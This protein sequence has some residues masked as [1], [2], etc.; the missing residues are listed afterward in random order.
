M[1]PEHRA[2]DV[3]GEVTGWRAWQIVGSLRVPRLMSINAAARV[4][5]DDAI[6]PTNRWL[7]ARCPRGHTDV[8][9]EGCSC[10][11]YAA[12]TRSHLV[13]LAYG[14]YG[15]GEIHAIGEVAFKG[16]V[17]EGTQ[18]WKAEAGRIK[19]LIVPYEFWRYVDPLAAAYSV[20][21]EVGLL[22]DERERERVLGGR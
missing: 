22:W 9:R 17:I 5:H 10:G 1:T 11:L 7:A 21:V 2:P 6:W 13:E 4:G 18:G 15:H 16:K 8:P 12:K 14:A 20:P 3:I 19:R